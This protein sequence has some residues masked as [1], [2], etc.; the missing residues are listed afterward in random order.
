MT[1]IQ[2]ECKVRGFYQWQTYSDRGQGLYIC[3][4]PRSSCVSYDVYYGDVILAL[5]K[6]YL[7]QKLYSYVL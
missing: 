3:R 6:L 5:C 2:P 1:N 4:T 7:Q